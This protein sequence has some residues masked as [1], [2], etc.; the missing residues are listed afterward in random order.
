MR[1]RFLLDL[2]ALTVVCAGAFSL[3]AQQSAAPATPSTGTETTACCESP[4]AT[5]YMSLG[6]GIVISHPGYR[7]C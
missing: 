1:K 6:D 7:P 4:G 5:C 2:A 3:S